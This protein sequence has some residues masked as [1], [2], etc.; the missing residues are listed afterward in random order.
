MAVVRLRILAARIF[1]LFRTPY[2]VVLL[3]RCRHLEFVDHPTYSQDITRQVP[4]NFYVVGLADCA[5][6]PDNALLD[7]GMERSLLQ[8]FRLRQRVADVLRDTGVILRLL[9]R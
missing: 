2:G 1:L 4:G 7:V 5:R 3:W 9:Q 6:K 8:R